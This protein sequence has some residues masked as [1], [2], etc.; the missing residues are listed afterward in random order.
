MILTLNQ[1]VAEQP[2]RAGYIA[3]LNPGAKYQNRKK[4][5]CFQ[6]DLRAAKRVRIGLTFNFIL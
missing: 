4:G 2:I 1:E 6:D 3:L 5:M